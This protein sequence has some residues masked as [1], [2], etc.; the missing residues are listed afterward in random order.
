MTNKP[1]TDSER[2]KHAPPASCY[3]KPK[4]LFFLNLEINVQQVN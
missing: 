3:K 2:A 1:N 4:I